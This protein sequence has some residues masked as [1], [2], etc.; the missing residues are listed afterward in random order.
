MK[1]LCIL[2]IFILLIASSSFAQKAEK[3]LNKKS[4]NSFPLIF[5][6]Y[7]KK[8]LSHEWKKYIKTFGGKVKKNKE[9]KEFFADDVT[10]KAISEKPIDIYATVFK[11]ENTSILTVWFN[12]NGVSVSPDAKTKTVTV[13]DEMLNE[14]TTIAISN[15][16]Q[17]N[18]Q[19]GAT[20]ATNDKANT[21][22]VPVA[23]KFVK[24]AQS[25]PGQ[26][27]STD[28]LHD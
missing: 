12:I 8:N 3:I 24:E 11:T 22:R 9:T 10:I 27:F 17:R 4:T 28:V 6:N 26:P 25:K 5:E 1:N 23:V 18:M 15:E 14:F 21:V 20:L 19:E 2:S 16:I 13:I 7:N